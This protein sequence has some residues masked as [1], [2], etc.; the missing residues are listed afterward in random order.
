MA[1][2]HV[3]L[4]LVLLRAGKI[5][6]AST[7]LQRALAIQS[8]HAAAHSYLAQALFRM[9]R[10]QE[11]IDHYEA[12]RAI[13]PGD[14]STLKNLAWILATCPQAY[15]RNGVRAVELGEQAD[16]LSGSSNPSILGTLAAAYA[17]TQLF[18]EALS[19]AR[20]ALHLASAQTNNAEADTLRA[21]IGLYQ[22]GSP[23]R[24]TAPQVMQ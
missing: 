4:G 19:T 9:G 18:D 2:T 1:Q 6:G 20:K 23:F 10:T 3:D 21:Q 16:R 17:E 11:A 12:A 7:R 8:N 5:Q 24:D 22:S 15:F 14:A 13:Q